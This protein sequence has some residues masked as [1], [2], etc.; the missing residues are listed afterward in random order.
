MAAIV[1]GGQTINPSTKDLLDAF[2][3]LPTDKV[4]ILPNNKNIILTAEQARAVTVKQVRIIPTRNIPQG[5][6]P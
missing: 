6:Q 3:N 4:I 5:W 2:E 1:P